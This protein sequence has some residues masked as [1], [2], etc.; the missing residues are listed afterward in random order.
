MD[1]VDGPDTLKEGS[2]GSP[3]PAGDIGFSS[4]APLANLSSVFRQ[5]K[6]SPQSG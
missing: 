4:T 1:E 2:R 6:K 5:G 3:V